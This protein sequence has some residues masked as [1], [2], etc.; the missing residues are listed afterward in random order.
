M[1]N[2]AACQMFGLTE[3]EIC[4]AGREGLVDVTDSRLK[5]ALEE[6]RGPEG[7]GELTKRK[8]GT[9]FPAELSTILFRD[10]DGGWKSTMIIR[11]IARRKRLE[12]VQ[13]RPQLP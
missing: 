2:S 8:D 7:L 11:D 9:V 10:A 6:R 12:E 5:L 4:L 13:K 3:E 1:A